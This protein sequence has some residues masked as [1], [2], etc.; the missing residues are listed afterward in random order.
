MPARAHLSEEAE[1]EEAEERVRLR[2]L[3]HKLRELRDRR[4]MV[5]A[6]VRKLSDEQKAL[7]DARHPREE[8]VERIHAEYRDLGV[9]LAEARTERD[10]GRRRLDEALAA[11]REFRASLPRQEHARPEQIK[12]EMRDIER[13]QQT[14]ALPLTEENALIDRLRKLTKELAA[15]ERD[16][17]VQEERHAK[18]K[19]LE[20]N[21]ADRRAEFAKRTETFERTKSERDARMASIRAR[22]VEAGKL[23][24]EIREKS[25]VR[26]E[27]MDKLRAISA[28]GDE[29]EREVD[30]LIRNSRDRRR[31][32]RAAITEYRKAFRGPMDME[33]A[34]ARQAEEQ[35]EEL[36][37]RGK[38]IL[39]G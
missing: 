4:Q 3:E 13:R 7:Y 8:E 37:K 26:T 35:L 25:K 30:R 38:V 22:L 33:T 29:V 18:L 14:T 12:R 36:L 32:A 34:M 21:L 10:E 20:K 24:A 11:V 31:E 15:A 1:K 9:R 39:R 5:F 23:V 6:E 27:A 28:Q 19:E 2:A 17:G 16:A